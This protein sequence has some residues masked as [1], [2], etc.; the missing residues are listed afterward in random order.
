MCSSPKLLLYYV[1]EFHETLYTVELPNLDTHVYCREFWFQQ[2]FKK[3][4]Q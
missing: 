1:L 4:I 3:L 2:V